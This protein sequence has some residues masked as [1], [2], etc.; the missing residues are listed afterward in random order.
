MTN[1]RGPDAPDPGRNDRACSDLPPL[2]RP[3]PDRLA[4]ARRQLQRK[5][6]A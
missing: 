2:P 4:A 3:D 5:P 1:G 6:S